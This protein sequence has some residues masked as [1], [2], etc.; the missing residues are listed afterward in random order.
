MSPASVR[1]AFLD[2]SWSVPSLLAI[3]LVLSIAVL[4]PLLGQ[5]EGELAP[6]TSKVTF[7]DVR[8]E[9]G[10][11]VFRM[12]FEKRRNCMLVGVTVKRFGVS[13]PAGPIPGQA[14][15]SGTVA[16]G[17]RVSQLW[18][19]PG[20]PPLDDVEVIFAHRCT[21]LWTTLTRAFP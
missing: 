18:A 13:V 1:K 15:P 4:G 10:S 17:E 12:A 8:E 16:P 9:D 21:F 6:V 2:Y 5:I 7:S 20:V 11:T 3:I 19:I 14:G